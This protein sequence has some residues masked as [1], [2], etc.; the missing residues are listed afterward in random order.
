MTMK[1]LVRAAVCEMEDISWG[2]VPDDSLRLQFGENPEVFAPCV[3]SMKNRLESVN[4]YPDPDKINLRR[5][6]AQREGVAMENV[7]L[8]NGV[9]GLIE[10]TAKVFCEDGDEVLLPAPTFPAYKASVQMMGGKVIHCPL[11]ADFSL[12]FERFV[13]CI[14]PR[15]KMIFLANPNNPTGNMLMSCDQIEALLKLFTGI[16]VIDEVYYEFS[17]VTTVGLLSKYKNLIVYRSFSKAYGLAGVRLGVGFADVE[18]LKYFRRAE[19]SSQVFAVN[20]L[21]LAAGE[22]VLENYEEAETFVASYQN[23]KYRFENLLA[24]IDGIEVHKTDTSF[25]LFSV[26]GKSDDFKTRMAERDVSVKSMSIFDF[27]PDNLVYCAVPRES[28][29]ESVIQNIEMSLER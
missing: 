4:R 25:C 10:L 2:Q 13:A 17:G 3:R 14:S 29:F 12:N 21:A 28:Q 6:L 19:G 7:F 20:S 16:V 15:T 5:L 27:V 11:R 22:A 18:I 23:K 26:P 24:Q 8:G 1:E 9:D